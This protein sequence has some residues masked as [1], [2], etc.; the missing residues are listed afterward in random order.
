VFGGEFGDFDE[1]FYDGGNRFG[2]GGQG[3]FGN[4]RYRRPFRNYGNYGRGRNGGRNDG[5][6]RYNVY[7]NRND[8][9]ATETQTNVAADI[10]DGAVTAAALAVSQN[11][12]QANGDPEDQ[13]GALGMEEPAR[14]NAAKNKKVDDVLCFRCSQ[15]GHLAPDCAAVLCIYCDS[16]LHAD[17]DCPM[18][19]MP[20]PTATLYG[21]CR[22][23]LMF[24]ELPKT[25]KYPH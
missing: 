3:Y 11:L 1:G 6:G 14:S 7:V 4:Q 8:T 23:G 15:K 17:A 18:L 25:K 9:N 24:F 21:L 22:E 19:H 16:A 5:R 20:K 10:N 2:Q 12:Q 13:N